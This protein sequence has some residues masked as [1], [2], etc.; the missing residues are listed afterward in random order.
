VL[1]GTR[2]GSLRMRRPHLFYLVMTMLLIWVYLYTLL[3]VVFSLQM[4]LIIKNV[5][6]A[7]HLS[8]TIIWLYFFIMKYVSKL[9]C[10]WVAS[11]FS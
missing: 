6:N 5:R 3:N 1:D 11:W 10:R 2:C 9:H 7:K 8:K 4:L